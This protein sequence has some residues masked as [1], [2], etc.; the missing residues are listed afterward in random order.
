MDGL[1]VL[2]LDKICLYDVFWGIYA[3]IEDVLISAIVVR[4]TG[5]GRLIPR[6]AWGC[7]WV[8]WV[9]LELMDWVLVCLAVFHC[10][11]SITDHCRMG[12]VAA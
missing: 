10:V 9:A 11:L 8:C 7:C 6:G 1:A 2:D 4:T 12:A 3:T 5:C